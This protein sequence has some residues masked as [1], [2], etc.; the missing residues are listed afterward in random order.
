MIWTHILV[1]LR[2]K[3]GRTLGGR[4]RFFHVLT[5]LFFLF[6]GK[7]VSGNGIQADDRLSGPR[8]T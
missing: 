1:E 2:Y 8:D 4:F 7:S 5:T 6:L 3:S